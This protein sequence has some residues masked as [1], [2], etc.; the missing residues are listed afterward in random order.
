MAKAFAAAVGSLVLMPILFL[1]ALVGAFHADPSL[2]AEVDP[3]FL[4]D[5]QALAAAV[6]QD[7]SIG[8]TSAAR[9]DVASG[10]MDPRVLAVLLV[11]SR[12]YRLTS[13][14]PLITGHSHFV[15]GT[16]RVSNH[17]FGRA[18]DITV[19]D[20]LG[21]SRANL[22]ALALMRDLVALPPSIRPDEVGG[23]WLV[24]ASGVRTFDDASHQDHAHFGWDHDLAPDGASHV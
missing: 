16:R 21:V 20:G 14:G 2:G 15:K 3:A 11:L 22:S 1:G 18:A 24:H 6:L 8:L 23:P 10:R 4:A 5:R 12:T 19:L 7:H 17:V 13:V 9:A